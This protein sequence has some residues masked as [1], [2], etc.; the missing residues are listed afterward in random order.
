MESLDSG[1]VLASALLLVSTFVIQPLQFLLPTFLIAR[2]QPR[3]GN[4]VRRCTVS[5]LMFM[6]ASIIAGIVA[7]AGMLG[8]VSELARYLLNF[9]SYSILLVLLVPCVLHCFD[10][11]F[12]NA[13][14]CATAAYSI[15]NL[16]SGAG[17]LIR[18]LVQWVTG[19]G[20]SLPL[21]VIAS[22]IAIFSVIALYHRLFISR[23]DSMDRLDEGVGDMLIM[24]VLVILVVIAYD[25]II[26]GL[27]NHGV[28][29]GFLVGLRVVHLAVCVFV[30]FAEYEMVFNARLEAEVA[31]RRMLSTEREHQ[32]RLSRETIKAVNRRVHDIRHQVFRDLAEGEVAVSDSVARALTRDIAVYDTL[33]ETGNDVLD[34][35]LTEKRLVC[36]R[37]GVTLSCIAD[38]SALAG[39]PIADL[40]A[41]FGSALDEAIEA[42]CALD[43]ETRRSISLTLRRVG[44][45]ALLHV[46]HYASGEA[47]EPPGLREIVDRYEGTL[48][49]SSREGTIAIDV[50]LS[51][52]P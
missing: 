28:A 12:W 33:V 16:G 27:G 52:Q 26:R 15:Q 17:E 21:T 43:D 7:W 34:T 10:T 38:G 11:G 5:Y 51:V 49:L 13:L 22:N 20:E 24:L 48:K 3:R 23:V 31:A 30:L 40:Y 4:F 9:V 47:E 25:V 37:R 8:L 42:V 18:L 44:D 1:S 50:M 45:L 14:F 46:E 32:Y 29:Y 39:L 35:I 6:L 41:L 19:V 2:R 36:Q